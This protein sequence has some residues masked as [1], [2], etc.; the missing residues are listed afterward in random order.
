MEHKKIICHQAH[1]ACLSSAKASVIGV[2]PTA[3]SSHIASCM[4]EDAK[5]P[6]P[7]PSPPI[8][9]PLRMDHF[10]RTS[11]ASANLMDT[12]FEPRAIGERR[13]L[14]RT[15][16]SPC[17]APASSQLDLSSPLWGIS[18]HF[19]TRRDATV[20]LPTHG[21]KLSA[22]AIAGIVAD[23]TA[24]VQEFPA[25]MLC[26]DTP[27]IVAIR[28][29]MHASKIDENPRKVDIG[30]DTSSSSRSSI[31]ACIG[32]ASDTTQP[33]FQRQK[34]TLTRSKRINKLP[35]PLPRSLPPGTNPPARCTSSTESLLPSRQMEYR[36][37][38]TM[39]MLNYY[40]EDMYPT[41]KI[42]RAHV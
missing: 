21:R 30:T 41:S 39:D 20:K 3:R 18:R 26:L 13:N 37:S 15:S 5:L 12:P 7:A 25:K 31:E 8:I 33:L 6:S 29:D 36:Y 2:T 27:C 17:M 35:S 19:P 34:S 1:T 10:P 23:I 24:S 4:N 28:H 38:P 11:S 14:A 32:L 40:R 16:T 42:G 9:Q 22:S